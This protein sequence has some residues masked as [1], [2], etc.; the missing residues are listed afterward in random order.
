MGGL[1]LAANYLAARGR[2]SP[3]TTYSDAE[4]ARVIESAQLG[5]RAVLGSPL[6]IVNL[7]GRRRS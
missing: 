2:C 5:N 4:I 3:F 7:W 6:L 1:L